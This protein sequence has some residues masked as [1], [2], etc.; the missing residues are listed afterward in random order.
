M[1]LLQALKD[2]DEEQDRIR[3][4]HREG[5]CRLLDWPWAVPSIVE[6]FDAKPAS[7]LCIDN[8]DHQKETASSASQVAKRLNLGKY[9]EF[10]RA[11]AFE[12]SSSF[13]KES[14]DMLWCDFGVGSRIDEFVKSTWE[15][16][17]PGGFLVL[18]STLTNKRTRDWLECTREGKDES[19][20]GLPLGEFKEISLLE[21]IKHYQNSIS[22]F[23]RR[24]KGRY[25][26]PLYSEYA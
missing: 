15:T 4:L 12:I 18:H 17:R 20:T 2:N 21:P 3:T 7:L 19:V 14:C 8:C 16:I 1:W 11:D 13:E 9:M 26:E 6:H 5:K 25:E 22:I 24:P 10:I 23:Q